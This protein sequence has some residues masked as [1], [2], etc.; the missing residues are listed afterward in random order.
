M[1]GW[2]RFG[3]GRLGRDSR[4]DGVTGIRFMTSDHHGIAGQ[5]KKDAHLGLYSSCI[6]NE[7]GR[8]FGTWI[9]VS[10][11]D[12]GSDGRHWNVQCKVCG[13]NK[14][15]RGPQIRRDACGK[16][17]PQPCPSCRTIAA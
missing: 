1:A 17:N 11:A 8:E 6:I 10:P 12:G 5:I 15:M 7:M 13:F 16:R 14:D 4:P 2:F 3:H 9:V